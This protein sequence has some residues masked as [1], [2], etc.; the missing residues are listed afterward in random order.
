MHWI[1]DILDVDPLF[2]DAGNGDFTLQ[3]DSPAIDAGLDFFVLDGDTLLDL[4]ED[5]YFGTAPDLGAYEYFP[6][7]KGDVNA[8]GEINILDIMRSVK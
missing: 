7:E 5:D 2:A 1:D 4:F 3:M 6:G 8:N